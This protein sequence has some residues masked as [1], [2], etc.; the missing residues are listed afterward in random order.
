MGEPEFVLVPFVAHLTFEV[1]VVREGELDRR[2][3]PGG[4]VNEERIG[5]QE[6]CLVWYGRDGTEGSLPVG[7]VASGLAEG[8][9]QTGQD[10]LC[11]VAM[12]PSS[13]LRN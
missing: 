8:C 11:R 6:G 13:S 10:D 9:G 4:A 12:P 3:R 5:P 7:P 2:D 1:G